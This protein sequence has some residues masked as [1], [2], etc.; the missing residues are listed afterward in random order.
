MLE[1]ISLKV[2]KIFAQECSNNVVGLT[3]TY[4]LWQGQICFLGFH[5]GRVIE[6]KGDFHAQINEYSKLTRT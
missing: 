6:L 5:I 1:H 2:L 4:I 3:M